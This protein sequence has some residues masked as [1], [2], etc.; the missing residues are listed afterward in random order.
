M[1]D[2]LA[3]LP[4]WLV[5]GVALGAICSVVVAGLFVVTERLFPSRRPSESGGDTEARRRSEIRAYLD[6]IGERYAEDHAVDGQLVAFYLPA[7]EVAITF[8][9]RT[10]FRLTGTATTPVLVEHEL[11]GVAIGP[12]LPFETPT[13]AVAGQGESHPASDAFARLGLPAGA[14]LADVRDAYR[15]RVKEVH[16]DQG[17]D[18]DTF[19]Q[20]REAYTTARRYA[21][22]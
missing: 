1:L 10:Y 6:R 16:P 9:A 20:V 17:G 12:R 21:S 4:S 14:S 5:V 8:D 15:E 13:T 3:E 2:S 18:E 19:R 11:P 7:R 22:D